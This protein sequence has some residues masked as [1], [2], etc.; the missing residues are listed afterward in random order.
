[1]V[2]EVGTAV[3][4]RGEELTAIDLRRAA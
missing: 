3:L 1:M 2:D 4:V